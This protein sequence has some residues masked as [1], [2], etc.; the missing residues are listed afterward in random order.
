MILAVLL[1]SS[2]YANFQRVHEEPEK[3]P[4]HIFTDYLR[5]IP[6][7]QYH[8]VLYD[9]RVRELDYADEYYM[10]RV[11]ADHITHTDDIRVIEQ[12]LRRPIPFICSPQ[13]V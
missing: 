3:L 9:L 13:T 4:I 12:L 5:D 10:D 2:L 1:S 7:D 11:P 8:L 6:D